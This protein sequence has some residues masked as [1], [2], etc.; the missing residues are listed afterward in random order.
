MKQLMCTND[1]ETWRQSPA[2]IIEGR[3]QHW[4]TPFA[5]TSPFPYRYLKVVIA[6]K[7]GN[8]GWYEKLKLKKKPFNQPTFT[9]VFQ[10]KFDIGFNRY[11]RKFIFSRF[12]SWFKQSLPHDWSYSNNALQL[13]ILGFQILHQ[14]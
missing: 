5:M 14:F 3:V 1:I 4:V 8:L 6:K 11:F 2:Y 10:E 13:L 7:P 12:I 9:F